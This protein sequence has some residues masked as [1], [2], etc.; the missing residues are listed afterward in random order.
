MDVKPK[1]VLHCK[2]DDYD[3]Y[4]I[5]SEDD[6]DHEH[7]KQESEHMMTHLKVHLRQQIKTARLKL[8]LNRHKTDGILPEE[9]KRG[10]VEISYQKESKDDG[11][12]IHREKPWYIIS[13]D[14]RAY[15]L[16]KFFS[17]LCSLFSSYFYAYIGAF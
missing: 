14:N 7:L 10:D 3:L 15:K 4:S 9:F 13:L 8:R 1:T 12:H 6:H 2:N 16:W 17:V 11:F 5:E